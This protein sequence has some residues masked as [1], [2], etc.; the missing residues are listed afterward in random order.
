MTRVL[1]TGA[2]GQLGR[3]LAATFADLDVVAADRAALDVTDRD[4]VLGA[5]TTLQPDL[6]IHPA[7]MTDVDAC[8]REPDRAYATNAM[9]TRH[10]ADGARR[11]GAHVVYVSTDYV[12]DGTKADPYHEW[13]TPNPLSHY[14]RSKLGGELE[15]D[16]GSTIVRTSWVFGRRGPNFITLVLGLA[17]KHEQLSIVDDQQGCPTPADEL[18]AMIRRLGADRRPGT[19]H[20]TGQGATSRYEQARVILAAAGHDP[21]RV[22]PIAPEELPTPRLAVRPVNSVLDNAALRLSGIPLLGEGQAALER[23]TKELTA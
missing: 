4:A 16:P 11:V 18:A 7:A 17:A 3:E 1:V 6:V 21:A 2:A 22:R 9:A 5:I 23:T 14:G 8:E 20:V 15:L 19:F 12:F 13:D 10:I